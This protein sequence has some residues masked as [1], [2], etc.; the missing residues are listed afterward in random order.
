MHLDIRK[1]IRIFLTE[2]VLAIYIAR[3]FLN[4]ELMTRMQRILTSN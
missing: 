2:V 1:Q 4:S 3:V